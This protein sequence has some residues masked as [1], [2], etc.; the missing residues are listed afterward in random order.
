MKKIALCVPTLTQYD[1][2]NL[3]I[4][5]AT[6]SSNTVL[7]SA[8]YIVDNNPNDRYEPPA[9]C[10]CPIIVHKPKSNLGVAASWNWF[11]N[12]VHPDH[13]YKNYILISNDDVKVY[14]ETL[15]H[16][17]DKIDETGAPVV[18]GAGGEWAFFAQDIHTLEAIGPY[19]ENFYPAYF[20]D[21]DYHYRLTLHGTDRAIASHAIYEHITSA[22]LKAKNRE[23]TLAHHE[24]FRKNH[25]YYVKK[26]GGTP[27]KETKKE[28]C[29]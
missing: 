26:W 28:P 8:I 4:K 2:L 17:I 13:T 24:S 14:P 12:N 29:L 6:A 15:A 25:E 7:P 16:L 27:G 5:S 20:E 22:T 23:E 21:N 1:R 11:L 9:Q 18:N 19:D 10:P 3:L